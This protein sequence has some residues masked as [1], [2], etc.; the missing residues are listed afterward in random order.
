MKLKEYLEGVDIFTLMD[1]IYPLPF[2]FDPPYQLTDLD[3][4]LKVLHGNKP[5]FSSFENLEPEIVANLLVLDFLEKWEKLVVVLA[6]VGNVNPRREITETITS[7]ETRTNTSN[8]LG[9]VSGFNSDELLTNDGSEVEGLDVSDGER[10][11]TLTDS[12]IN[13]QL[14]FNMLNVIDQNSILQT[15]MADVSKYLTLSIYK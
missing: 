3:L 14:T 11:R 10:V 2:M 1:D 7:E 13:L 15:V 6:Q 4:R 9:K 5:L 12:Q 8:T